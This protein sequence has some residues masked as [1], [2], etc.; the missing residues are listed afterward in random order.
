[1]TLCSSK[2]KSVVGTM[3][4]FL[5]GL[6][7]APIATAGPIL[8]DDGIVYIEKD[9]SPLGTSPIADPAGNPVGVINYNGGQILL[10]DY[11]GD[12]L[13]TYVPPDPWWWNAPGVAYT[14]TTS[15]ILI[16]FVDL[17]VTGFTFNIG[18]NMNAQAWIK[19]YYDDG[20]GH[21]L[22][23]TWFSGIGPTKTPGFG[24]YV[25]NPS[26]SCAQITR[27]EVDPTFEWGIG[28]FGISES[29][30]T[31]VPEPASTTLLGIGM[32]I[33]AMGQYLVHNR[34]IKIALVSKG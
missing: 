34:R 1:M 30:C 23:T 28:N 24:V 16:D 5:A 18:A 9:P 20:T 29:S 26:E 32:L 3:A 4:I 6:S 7:C 17:D 8:A 11:N 21:E 19:A 22:S 2:F 27:I 13:N 25:H 31:T 10:E 14:T 33:L 12:P 15:G